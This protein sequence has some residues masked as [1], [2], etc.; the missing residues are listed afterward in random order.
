MIKSK[1]RVT[2]QNIVD[3]SVKGI[4]EKKGTD[5]VVI[6][7]KKIGNAVASYFVICTGSS[8]TQLQAIAESVEKEVYLN[9]EENP[10]HK[11][12]FQNREWILIDYVDVVIHIFKREV[13]EYYGIEDL[14]G[15]AEI[16]W[17]EEAVAKQKVSK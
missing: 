1:D 4:Q 14:W 8:D 7:L 3:F 11:E 15:D 6:N 16:E 10:W 5:I 13:R 9:C 12:G 2:S 17:I